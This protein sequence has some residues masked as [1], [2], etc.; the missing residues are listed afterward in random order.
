MWVVP[1]GLHANLVKMETRNITSQG[2]G[3]D[4]TIVDQIGGQLGQKKKKR[5]ALFGF[6]QWWRRHRV[7][8]SLLVPPSEQTGNYS[9]NLRKETGQL[10]LREKSQLS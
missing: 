7:Q 3:K 10:C 2:F 8:G 9:Q 1:L 5:I 4:K 6:L